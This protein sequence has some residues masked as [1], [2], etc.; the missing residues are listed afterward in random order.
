[1]KIKAFFKK[2]KFKI[3]S[4]YWSIRLKMMG[5]NDTDNTDP[6]IYD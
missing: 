2:I 4:W 1:M 3:I 5:V 6:F